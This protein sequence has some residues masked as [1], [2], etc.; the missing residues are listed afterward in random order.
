M[1]TASCF[2]K[3]LGVFILALVAF[4]ALTCLRMARYHHFFGTIGGISPQDSGSHAAFRE[5][6]NSLLI[7]DG[8]DVVLW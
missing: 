3:R 6:Q 1:K 5:L 8:K 2:L 7:V 4:T